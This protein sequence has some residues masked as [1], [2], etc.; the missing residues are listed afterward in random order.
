M[1]KR[2]NS[3]NVVNSG[4]NRTEKSGLTPFYEAL[5]GAL[6]PACGCKDVPSLSLPRSASLACWLRRTAP[7]DSSFLGISWGSRRRV[8]L[9]PIYF[10]TT[11]FKEY[12]LIPGLCRL[13]EV[14]DPLLIKSIS[15]KNLSPC[16]HFWTLLIFYYGSI[17]DLSLMLGLSL[18][19]KAEGSRHVIGRR[20][21]RGWIV[22]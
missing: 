12:Y 5:L 21:L 6:I 16:K 19:L 3:K 9:L 1:I 7:P 15:H 4:V 2:R 10:L 22:N 13:Q 17:A 8:R 14:C 20:E 18:K 11:D